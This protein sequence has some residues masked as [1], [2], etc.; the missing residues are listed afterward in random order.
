MYVMK[1][2]KNE[3]RLS[4]ATLWLWIGVSVLVILLIIWLTIFEYWSA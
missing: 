2:R 4:S 3:S 1:E